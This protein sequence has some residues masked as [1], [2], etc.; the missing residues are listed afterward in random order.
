MRSL[1]TYLYNLK[2]GLFKNNLKQTQ[3][4]A[5]VGSKEE[6]QRTENLMTIG[7]RNKKKVFKISTSK[8]ENNNEFYD[9]DIFQLNDAFCNGIGNRTA[10]VANQL[11]H[12]K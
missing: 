9:G 8:I 1:L 12:L 7:N 4:I 2:I 10:F 11:R 3:I 5:L 6:I